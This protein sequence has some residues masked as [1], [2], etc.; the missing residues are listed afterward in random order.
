[1]TSSIA[2]TADLVYGLFSCQFWIIWVF[3][4]TEFITIFQW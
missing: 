4:W 2:D 1:M 3:D